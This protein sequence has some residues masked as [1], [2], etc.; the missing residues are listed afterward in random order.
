MA[1][2]P[3]ELRR[4]NWSECFPF[5][6]LF[7]TF[8]LAIHPTKLM[9]CF[10]ALLASYGTGRLLDVIWLAAGQGGAYDEAAKYAFHAD[11]GTWRQQRVEQMEGDLARF[12]V[13][14]GVADNAD[15]ARRD[16]QRDWKRAGEDVLARLRDRLESATNKEARQSA[17]S[18]ATAGLS[19]EEKNR[20]EARFEADWPKQVASARRQFLEQ[21]DRL[22]ELR[23]HGV[24][25]ELLR[26]EWFYGRTALQ[27]ARMGA[28]VGQFET[29]TLPG[30]DRP[31]EL[32]GILS[33]RDPASLG[34]VGSL[35]MMAYGFGWLVTQH[36]LF[37]I[38][39]LAVSLAIWSILGGAVCRVAAIHVARDEK[40]SLQKAVRFAW[41]RKVSTFMAPLL[42]L[43]AVVFFG[44]LLFLGGLIASIPYLQAVSGPLLSLGFGFALLVGFIIAVT[45]VGLVGAGCLMWPT[46]AVEGSD[47]FD[48]I[49]RSYSYVFTKP[50]R[51]LFYTLVA[52]CY[53][54]FCYLFITLFTWLLLSATHWFVGLGTRMLAAR[55]AAGEG[56]SKIDALWTAPSFANLRPRFESIY[57][58]SAPEWMSAILVMLWVYLLVGLT[59]AFLVSFFFSGSTI[60]YFLLRREVDATDL[61]DV[62]PDEY[63]EEPL[64]P[65]PK[66]TE[67][68]APTPAEGS[69][70][71]PS[72][73]LPVVGGGTTGTPPPEQGP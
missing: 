3:Q 33:R 11:F 51:T 37:A 4:I 9:L 72:V 38:I 5:T 34:V 45:L 10:A 15:D 67:P 26:H 43:G 46:I 49:S 25:R 65:G 40:I 35:L 1:E 62:Y 39:F 30:A 27:A 32:S 28:I 48:A 69:D 66:P 24:F 2:D 14:T 60:M 70:K 23:P 7:R 52:L 71:G 16:V 8:R 42:P 55:P 63:E 54:A 29:I 73:P 58:E 56:L 6:H 21:R 36:W 22:Q 68:A 20:A 44:F 19:G 57:L 64:A 13:E 59:Y 12:M 47:S 31:G 53:G 61:E 50:W 17:R 41:Q 18:S